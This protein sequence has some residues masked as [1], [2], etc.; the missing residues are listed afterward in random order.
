[1]EAVIDKDLAPALLAIDLGA[2]VL[3]LATDVSAVHTGWGTRAA[4]RHLCHA[5]LAASAALPGRLD[6]PQGGV[7]L[8]VRGG[9]RRPRGIGQLEEPA[10]DGRHTWHADPGQGSGRRMSW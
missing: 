1:M 9:D 8:P 4:G 10:L 5:G 2:E 6:G 3:V 7:C